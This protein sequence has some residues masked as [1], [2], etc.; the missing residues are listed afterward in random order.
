MRRLLLFSGLVGA[1]ASCTTASESTTSTKP[2]RD[3]V[4]HNTIV[5]CI[6]YDG[7][8]KTSPQLLTITAGSEVQVTD[9]VDYY[10]MKARVVKDGKTYTGY[11]QRQCFS[12]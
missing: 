1:F 6:L 4:A 2:D 10:F 3:P 8:T 9:T 7:M 12:K 11:V 5:E